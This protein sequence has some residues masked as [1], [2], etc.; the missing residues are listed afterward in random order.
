[1]TIINQKVSKDEVDEPSVDANVE[2]VA[3]AGEK[4]T[5]DTAT[6]TDNDKKTC[7]NCGAEVESSNAFCGKCGTKL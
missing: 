6:E 1:M 7:P 5:E 3:T 4:P 2:T